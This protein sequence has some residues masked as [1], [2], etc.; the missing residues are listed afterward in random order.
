LANQ[1]GLW[2]VRRDFGKR[3]FGKS[4]RVLANQE[5][6]WQLKRDFGYSGGT[7]VIQEEVWKFDWLYI[8]NSF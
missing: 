3:D 4:G 1:E 2:Q 8:V 7:L 5:V 6:L